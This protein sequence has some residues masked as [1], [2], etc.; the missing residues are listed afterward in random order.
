MIKCELYKQ[1]P[2]S[3]TQF[4]SSTLLTRPCS[5]SFFILVICKLFKFLRNVYKTTVK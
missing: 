3:V 1:F 4:T 5:T 2:A